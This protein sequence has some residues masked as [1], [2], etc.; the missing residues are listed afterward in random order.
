[1]REA[2]QPLILYATVYR[3]QCEAN[4]VQ[5]R[6]VS[7]LN[8]TSGNYP[9]LVRKYCDDNV[10]AMVGG[11]DPSIAPDGLSF[12]WTLSWALKQTATAEPC[13]HCGE[14]SL[15]QD[16]SLTLAVWPV[17]CFVQQGRG[18]ISC[19][20][21]VALDRASNRVYKCLQDIIERYHQLQVAATFGHQLTHEEQTQPAARY[22]QAVDI[23]LTHMMLSVI[24]EHEKLNE[25]EIKEFRRY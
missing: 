18:G 25:G 6:R 4:Q 10:A 19:M 15:D 24:D 23:D 1:M 9:S 17:E 2:V 12:R 7:E 21:L 3:Q 5:I 13:L 16:P 11:A 22:S 20:C 14:G 8:L